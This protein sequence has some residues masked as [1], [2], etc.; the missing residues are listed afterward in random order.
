MSTNPLLCPAL[1][2]AVSLLFLPMAGAQ[3]DGCPVDKCVESETSHVFDPQ[4]NRM[5]AFS[6]ATTDYNTAYWYDLCV[7]LAVVRLNGPYRS[8]PSH[9]RAILRRILV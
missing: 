5:D 2:L 1:A 9:L 4:T 3:V 6:T 8:P 7:N